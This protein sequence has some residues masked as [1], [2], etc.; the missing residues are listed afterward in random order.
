MEPI[1][2]IFSISENNFKELGSPMRETTIAVL[3]ILLFFSISHAGE[4]HTEALSK[5]SNFLISLP[6]EYKIEKAQG[7]PS[8]TYEIRKDKNSLLMI[9]P[10]P[11][12]SVPLD[13][14]QANVA[15]QGSGL[16]KNSEEEK[17][18]LVD[19]KQGEQTSGYYYVLTDKEPK[20]GEY[21][22]LHQGAF[23]IENGLIYFTFLSN[24]KKSKEF[25]TILTLL[26]NI[27]LQSNP[28]YLSPFSNLVISQEEL[29]EKVKIGNELYLKTYQI[30]LYIKDPAIYDSLIPKLENIEIQSIEK[31]EDKGSII[32][33]KYNEQ[34]KK[35]YSFLSGLFYG[36]ATPG[37]EEHPE[38]MFHNNDTIIILSY[39]PESA[40]KKKLMKIIKQKI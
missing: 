36:E 19:F 9:T 16:L 20:P 35:A 5:K 7:S 40:L 13:R 17:L 28:N 29:G 6:D 10:Y 3:F 37:S 22:Y 18:S 23:L 14:L 2:W 12:E 34:I 30:F 8:V 27:Q 4:V 25:K 32:Y 21:K 1:F 26:N 31:G 39:P 38:E 33:L 11:G 24:E 15:R